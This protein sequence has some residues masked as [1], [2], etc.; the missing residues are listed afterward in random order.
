MFG[1][2]GGVSCCQ[3][4]QLRPRNLSD[5]RQDQDRARRHRQSKSNATQNSAMV[6]QSLEDRLHRTTGPKSAC[7]RTR[8]NFEHALEHCTVRANFYRTQTLCHAQ[9]ERKQFASTWNAVLPRTGMWE[10]KR[11]SC[12]VSWPSATAPIRS[13]GR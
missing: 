8:T 4:V 13:A 12:T 6:D 1:S 3:Q 11:R 7:A 9:P 5:V 10:M 2:D